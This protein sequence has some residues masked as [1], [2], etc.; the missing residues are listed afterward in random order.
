LKLSQRVKFWV[1]GVLGHLLVRALVCTLRVKVI[2]SKLPPR[3]GGKGFVFAFWH[4]QLLSFSYLY[5]NLNIHVLVSSHRDGEYIVQVTRRLGFAAVRGSSTRGG[6]R[7]LSEALDK[8]QQGQDVAVTPDGPRGPRQH[9]KPGALFLARE[10][11]SP[12][13]LGSCVPHKAWRLKSW[14]GFYI[15]KPFSR[16]V[17]IVGEPIFVPR[18]A[19]DAEMEAM[20]VELENRLNDMTR[21][22]EEGGEASER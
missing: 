11:G 21:Q 10:S 2:G 4:A 22:A 7:V 1:V 9:F 13:V 5:R 8:L 14:D 19:T 17:L 6:V 18:E 12:I 15:P 3:P 16:A 20:R